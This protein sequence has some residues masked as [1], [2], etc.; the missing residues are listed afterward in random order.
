MGKKHK[1]DKQADL[2][3]EPDYVGLA[4]L[5][6]QALLELG[7]KAAELRNAI[8]SMREGV[9]LEQKRVSGKIAEIERELASVSTTLLD[10]REARKQ[11]PL[12]FEAQVGPDQASATLAEVARVAEEQGL[13]AGAEPAPS[14][15]GP[16]PEELSAEPAECTAC[17]SAVKRA[18][19]AGVFMCSSPSCDWVGCVVADDGERVE[20][21]EPSIDRTAEPEVSPSEFEACTKCGGPIAEIDPAGRDERQFRCADWSGGCDWIGVVRPEAAVASEPPFDFGADEPAPA[22]EAAEEA[23]PEPARVLPMHGRRKPKTRA[24][25]AAAESAGASA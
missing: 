9:R 5:S 10:A 12:E 23:Q 21:P 20:E 14:L 11:R 13:V 3:L 7:F 4:K 15:D 18:P 6:D 25:V 8:A 2:G 16:E 19:A 22:V 17:K 1:A 24:E